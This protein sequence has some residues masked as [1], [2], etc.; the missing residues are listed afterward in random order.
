MTVGKVTIKKHDKGVGWYRMTITSLKNFIGETTVDLLVREETLRKIR[1][2][3][4]RALTD[5]NTP[6]PLDAL[7]E[8]K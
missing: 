1:N 8:D 7:R 4:D 6:N 5:K 2:E 3:A